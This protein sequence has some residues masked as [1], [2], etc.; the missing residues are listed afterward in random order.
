LEWYTEEAGEDVYDVL[1]VY[2]H[3]HMKINAHAVE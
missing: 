3:I 1:P 2:V